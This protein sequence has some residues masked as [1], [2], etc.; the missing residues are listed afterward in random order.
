MRQ[1]NL[2][3]VEAG[4]GQRIGALALDHIDLHALLGQSQG[5]TKTGGT[6]TDDDDMTSLHDF[7]RGPHARPKHA[8]GESMRAP[9]A[10]F[11][12]DQDG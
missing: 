3:A 11:D 1:R 5:Q 4:F 7:L 12:L 2:A 6:S 9:E 10:V 8:L